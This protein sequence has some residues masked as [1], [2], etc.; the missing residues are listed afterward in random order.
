MHMDAE[1]QEIVV[2]A[3]IS[4]VVRLLETVQDLNKV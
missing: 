2:C 3:G 4:G 1:N